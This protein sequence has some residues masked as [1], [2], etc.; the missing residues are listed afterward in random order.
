MP[1]S[2][3]HLKC[4]LRLLRTSV[5][6]STFRH[7]VRLGEC[8]PSASCAAK[9]APACWADTYTHERKDAVKK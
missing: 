2:T 9:A 1:Y 3:L 7:A 5:M 6:A 4:M 8:A